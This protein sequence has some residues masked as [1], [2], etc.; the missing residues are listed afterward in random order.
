ME[1]LYIL[2]CFLH[3]Y[4]HP[5]LSGTQYSKPRWHL[6]KCAG[7]SHQLKSQSCKHSCLGTICMTYR[8]FSEFLL[9][10]TTFLRL[11]WSVF[12][13]IA[14]DK[15]AQMLE[16]IFLR[17]STEFKSVVSWFRCCRLEAKQN[18]MA[19]GTHVGGQ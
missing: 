1:D 9:N 18:T 19:T 16:L 2:A 10:Y 12:M 4:G 8:Y 15:K 11:F 3:L 14:K 6:Q 5:S 7:L 17:S 13:Y